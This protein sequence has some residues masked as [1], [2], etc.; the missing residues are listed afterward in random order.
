M[1]P[2]SNLTFHCSTC[3]K[4]MAVN[5]PM[6]DAI[7]EKGCVVCGTSVSRSAFSPVASANGDGTA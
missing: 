6:R 2:G 7:L 1:R 4:S 3:D 5:G